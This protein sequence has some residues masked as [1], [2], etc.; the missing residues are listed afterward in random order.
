MQDHA[1][2]T[3]KRHPEAEA[4]RRSAVA[5]IKLLLSDSQELLPTHRREF[6]RLALWKITEAETAKYQTDQGISSG[7]QLGTGLARGLCRAFM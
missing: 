4:R 1:T 3:Y 5:L 7:P 6:L 2:M